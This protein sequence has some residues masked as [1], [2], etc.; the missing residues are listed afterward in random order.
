M[1]ALLRRRLL[2]LYLL[3]AISIGVALIGMAQSAWVNIGAN[4]VPELERKTEAVA[5]SLKDRLIKALDLGIPFESI[6]GAEEYFGEVLQNNRELAFIAL[7]GPDGTL[8]HAAGAE[9][10]RISDALDK[11]RPRKSRT[12]SEAIWKDLSTDNPNGIGQIVSL[13]LMQSQILVGH[14]HLGV[15]AGHLEGQLAGTRLELFVLL[16]VAVIIAIE[17]LRY[18]LLPR[19]MT[20]PAPANAPDVRSAS[21]NRSAAIRFI[22]PVRLITLLFMFGEQ[23]SRPFLPVF[24]GKLMPAG[25]SDSYSAVVAGV[26][27]SVFMLT[28]ALAMPYLTGW[29]RRF[30]LRS[31]FLA[32]AYVAVIGLIGAAFCVS[33]WDLA[34]W[35][36]ITA[37]GYALMYLACQNFILDNTTDAERVQGLAV[38]VGAIMVAELCAPGIGGMLA[39][40]I[41]ERAVFAIGAGVML[42]SAA[43]GA[44]VLS[45]TACSAGKSAE[46][47]GAGMALLR[48]LRFAILITTAAIPAKFALTAFL[49]YLVP[50][51]LS[52]FA[53]NY[54]EIGRVAMLYAIPSLLAAAWISRIAERMRMDGLLVA[55]G[56]IVAGAGLIP[57]LFW[58]GPETV[59]IGVLALGLGH[60]LS[61]SS[62]LSL[63]SLVCEKEMALHGASSVF[64]FFRFVER[65]GAALGP[66][67]AGIL[68]AFF[69][70]I[71][72]AGILG[73]FSFSCAII[74]AVLFLVLGARPEIDFFP[75]APE[76]RGGAS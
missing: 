72:T 21:G 24:A 4:L 40:H 69:G 35:R 65:L 39:D 76:K 14:L 27:I 43:L 32:G 74:F 1:F 5:F 52:S 36:A 54:G 73:V 19:G 48:N 12:E 22:L 20:S 26:P 8:F 68:T 47:L 2:S 17:T 71:E 29:T 31:S 38:F 49:F 33:I 41:G 75:A 50:V 67:A 18:V 34:F 58:P 60:A 70:P 44:T 53:A 46:T 51:S 62:Q 64:G 57:M 13:P 63:V 3:A 10:N 61:I 6:E 42:L 45:N 37:L 9:E 23:L 55:L 25:A 66:L 59:A 15:Q 56:G 28:V 7:S 11:V 16:I 30:G